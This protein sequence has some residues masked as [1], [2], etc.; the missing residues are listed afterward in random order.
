MVRPPPQPRRTRRLVTPATATALLL[1]AAL[2]LLQNKMSGSMEAQQRQLQQANRRAAL[3]GREARAVL[4]Q[5][6]DAGSLGSGAAA[7]LGDGAATSA[8]RRVAE[9]EARMNA[10]QALKPGDPQ[11]LD[12]PM[13]QLA[14]A[15][16]LTSFSGPNLT[17][18]VSARVPK[19]A[20]MFLTMGEQG[21]C[22]AAVGKRQGR[23][24]ATIAGAPA[25]RNC[26][27]P[28]S[29][30]P[31]WQTPARHAGPLPHERLW[32]EWLR[33]AGGL[34]PRSALAPE[35]AL[36]LSQC[37]ASGKCQ[38]R[39]GPAAACNP[40]CSNALRA[41]YGRERG[42]RVEQ[43]QNLFSIYVHAPP[44]FPGYNDSSMF[45]GKLLR[46]RLSTEWGTHSLTQAAKNM[47]EEAV[48]DADN[49]ARSGRAVRWFGL[50]QLL[51]GGPC[52][53]PCTVIA[54]VPAACMAHGRPPPA[55]APAQ[56]FLLIS[57]TT[58]PLYS[59]PMLWQQL[60]HERKSRID[61]CPHD[62][63]LQWVCVCWGG[64][65]VTGGQAWCSFYWSLVLC[66]WSAF[67]PCQA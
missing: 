29:L 13:P 3:G 23:W 30:R 67:A 37:D 21:P 11:A 45:A 39:C 20:L 34:L 2:V 6:A 51:S 42:A 16:D 28:T 43:Q 64:G 36:C 52:V 18:V 55:P 27:A 50:E 7:G 59:A 63:R 17:C 66:C 8:E 32:V 46:G 25:C 38:S 31:A 53:A 54:L 62:V 61:A 58:V 65:G 49:E 33:K 19:L 41:A 26:C 5:Q 60:M 56:W 10:Q 57:D 22:R 48:K 47:I 44:A 12:L 9:F 1:F 35:Q 15:P 24:V 4:L 40:I 14:D